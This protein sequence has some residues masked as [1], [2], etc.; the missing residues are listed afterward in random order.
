MARANRKN[1]AQNRQSSGTIPPSPNAAAEKL[2]ELL[3][4]KQTIP[5]HENIPDKEFPIVTYSVYGAPET[6][7]LFVKLTNGTVTFVEAIESPLLSPPMADRIF[8][9]DVLDHAVASDLAD[10]MWEKHKA[11]LISNPPTQKPPP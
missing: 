10:Q 6:N 5:Y 1:S 11:A 9:L 8:G 4:A 7:E 3:L 2:A